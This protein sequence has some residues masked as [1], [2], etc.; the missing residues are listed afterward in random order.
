MR[1]LTVADSCRHAGRNTISTDDIM[2]LARRNEGLE[3]VLRN[4]LDKQQ[5]GKNKAII[6]K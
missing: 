2:L 6:R 1:H 3:T 5:A 4:F